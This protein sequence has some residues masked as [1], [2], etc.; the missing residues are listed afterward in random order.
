[1]VQLL[2]ENDPAVDEEDGQIPHKGYRVAS[3]REC[4][5]QTNWKLAIAPEAP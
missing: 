1:V 2:V 4:E 3:L 5:P